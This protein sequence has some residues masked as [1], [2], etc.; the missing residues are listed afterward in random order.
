MAEIVKAKPYKINIVYSTLAEQGEAE[1]IENCTNSQIKQKIL[2]AFENLSN[3][4]KWRGF[5]KKEY[6]GETLHID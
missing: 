3:K 4:N 1:K 2:Y 6:A 5:H